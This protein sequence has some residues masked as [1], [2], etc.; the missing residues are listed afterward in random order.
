MDLKAIF[1]EIFDWI[2]LILDIDCLWNLVN[3]AVNFWFHKMMGIS[4]EA[5][6]LLPLSLSRKLFPSQLVS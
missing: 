5:K 1:W 2:R 6:L 3:M 4:S